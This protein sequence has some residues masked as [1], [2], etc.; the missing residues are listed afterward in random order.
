M[1][2]L[3]QKDVSFHDQTASSCACLDWSDA[4][5][6]FGAKCG[7]GHEMDIAE[8]IPG[9][10]AA[11]IPQL[12][13]EF[14]GQYFGNLPKDNFCQKTRFDAGTKQWCYVKAECAVGERSQGSGSV[15]TKWCSEGQDKILGDMKFEDFAAYA[16]KN[17]LELGLMVQYAYPTFEF[18]DAAGETKLPDVQSFWGLAPGSD[19]KPMTEELRQRLQEVKDSGKTTFFTSRS[20]H[21]AFGVAEGE[22][23][24]WINFSKINSFWSMQGKQWEH[25]EDMNHW[26]CVAGCEL[27]SAVW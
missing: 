8:G 4:Y 27:V 19:A 12:H 2:S 13:D 17:K 22:K 15:K 9:P 7:D 10:Q 18:E 1:T 24:Y 14:C 20:G 26:A 11:A 21:P 3:I 23:F 16:H 25:K 5:Q 6:V